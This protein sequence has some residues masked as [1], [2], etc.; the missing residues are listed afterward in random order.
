[1]KEYNRKTRK[2][3]VITEVVGDLKKRDT[4]RGKKPHDFVLVLP[5]HLR[6]YYMVD[7]TTENVEKYYES[8]DRIWEFEEKEKKYKESLGIV[9][10]NGRSIYSSRRATRNYECS[11]CGKKEWREVS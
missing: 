1:M 11:V 3:E 10:S 6:N 9:R 8:E 2:W 5:D 7:I 4:C